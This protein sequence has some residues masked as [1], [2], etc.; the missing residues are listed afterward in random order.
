ML[1]FLIMLSLL[2]HL[3]TFSIIRKLHTK[4]ENMANGT[5]SKSAAEETEQMLNRFLDDIK[6][7]NNRLKSML[8][9]RDSRHRNVEPVQK[10]MDESKSGKDAEKGDIPAGYSAPYTPPLP[11]Q[12]GDKVEQ[13]EAGMVIS[14]YEQ[15]HSLE[16]IA[17]KINR[18]KTEV[19]LLL[20]F[21]R[22]N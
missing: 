9:E 17:R 13:S 7:E 2:L 18:G 5:D 6:E 16:E 22:K 12:S 10:D 11:S 15:G 20:K 14:L 3:V 19:E 4:L 21:Y 1:L 8:D